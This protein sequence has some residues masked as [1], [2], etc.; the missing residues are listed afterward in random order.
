MSDFVGAAR[1]LPGYEPLGSAVRTDAERWPS[2][3]ERGLQRV[4]A[5]RA[6]PQ[7]PRWTHECGD[8]LTADDHVELARWAAELEETTVAAGAPP[9]YV[10]GQLD[11]LLSLVPFYRRLGARAWSDLPTITRAD[12][13]RSVADFVPTDADL[14][15]VV[16]GTSSGSTGSA[17][18][19]PWHPLDISKDLP[20]LEHLLGW[21]GVAWPRDEQRVGLLSVVNQE[22]AFTYA[23]A[24]TWRDEQLMG[25]VN[26]HAGAW[27]AP[28][29]RERFLEEAVAQVVS[30]SALTLLDYAD[31]ELSTRP[32][33]MVSGAVDLSVAAREHLE[34]S[35]GATVLNLYG[36]RETGP[37]AVEVG[38]AAA[39]TGRPTEGHLL[40]P[41]RL[42]VEVVDEQGQSL[43]DGVRGEVVVTS[44]ENPYLPLLR[45]RTGDRAALV[46]CGSR[47]RLLGLEG[48]A[49][50]T[51]VRGDGTSQQSVELTQRLQQHGVRAW[52]VRQEVDGSV[53]ARCVGGD[54]AG[55]KDALETLLD[56]PVEVHAVPSAG[57]LGPGKPQRFESALRR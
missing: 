14:S 29:D 18:V 44:L 25:R 21:A 3:S 43:P 28:G 22:Q 10:V 27:S 4:V 53:I 52:T 24:M 31:L 39:A 41:R 26:L 51:F 57:A 8:L 12:L 6:H 32:L 46:G 9:P 48:R 16:Q 38:A 33:A 20:L 17:L 13:A 50:V 40:V 35:Y 37:V 45:Y 2:M 23:S 30:G 49:A 19:I 42:H 47:R 7:A 5:L 34:Q 56:R 15:R 11:R 1:A 54:H 36:L 55:L